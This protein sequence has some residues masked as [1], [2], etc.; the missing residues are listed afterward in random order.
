V[1]VGIATATVNR[2]PVYVFRNV[3]NRSREMSERTLDND[4]RNNFAKSG[5]NSA[6]GFGD[7]R[8]YIFHN[9]LLQ[10]T[11]PS[12]VYPLG[13]GGGISGAG[14]PITNTVSRNNIL[15]IWK[16]SWGSIDQTGWGVD[17]DYDLYNGTVAVREPR[18]IQGRPVYQSG[19]GWT[20]ESNGM[21]QLSPTSPGYDAGVRLPNFNDD[22]Q[23]A[24]PDMG[25]HE[26][27]SP[28]MKFGVNQ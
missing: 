19:N 8:R 11:D 9:T 2:G 3:L 18:G 4:D 7:G 16:D 6:T 14:A 22:F 21:Y 13:A 10:A 1:T 27:G 15:N 17:A 26:A 5:R 25:A 12:A 23:G 20:S 28:A 24:G